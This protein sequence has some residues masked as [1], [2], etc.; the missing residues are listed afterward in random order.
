MTIRKNI[1]AMLLAVAGIIPPAVLSQITKPHSFVDN[2]K[3][4]TY[5]DT[6]GV[7][8][9]YIAHFG[10]KFIVDSIITPGGESLLLSAQP[11]VT[12]YNFWFVACKPCI[13]EIP[14]LN[15]LAE[16]YGS[17]S[18]QF[19]AITFDDAER[20]KTFL[21][22][23]RFDFMI[24]TLPMETINKIKKVAY[25]PFTAVVNR[26]QKLSFVLTGR[27]VGKDPGR[28]IFEVLDPQ[29]HKALQQ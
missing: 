17:D 2:G 6:G 10:E 12:V 20:I 22:K 4:Y 19:I 7:T 24:G 1:T 11:K 8:A 14:A 16:K 18:V 13:A 5:T 3:K 25:Y 23:N 27:P 26:H 29:I 9:S 21:E 28:E 15:R